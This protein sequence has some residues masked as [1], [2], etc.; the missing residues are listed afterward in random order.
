MSSKEFGFYFVGSS[1]FLRLLIKA[2]TYTCTCMHVH[3]CTLTHTY[4]SYGSRE[5]SLDISEIA[6]VGEGYKNQYS[7]DGIGN[8][9]GERRLRNNTKK[10][11]YYFLLTGTV[12][13]SLHFILYIPARV[14]FL[15]YMSGHA[16]S[17]Y[18]LPLAS[19]CN[20]IKSMVTKSY[21]SI[22]HLI[23]SRMTVFFLFLKYTVLFLSILLELLYLLFLLLIKPLLYSFIII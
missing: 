3:V 5:T 23:W 7:V 11:D 10:K 21:H 15:K 12:H 14:I 16:I 2:Y 1:E 22:P 9:K 8:R 13:S 20:Q 18:S 6:Q 17:V 19:C 4:T